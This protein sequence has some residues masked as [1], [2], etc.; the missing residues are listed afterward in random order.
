[1]EY[2]TVINLLTVFMTWA[3][4]SETTKRLIASVKEVQGSLGEMGNT[5]YNLDDIW[6]VNRKYVGEQKKTSF[7]A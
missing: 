5:A 1:M 6:P 3:I 2:G 7:M 4:V